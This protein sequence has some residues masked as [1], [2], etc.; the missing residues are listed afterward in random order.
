MVG[1]KVIDAEAGKN[2]G[3]EGILVRHQHG[4]DFPFFKTLLDFAQSLKK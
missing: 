1:D 2:A 4:S 3:V